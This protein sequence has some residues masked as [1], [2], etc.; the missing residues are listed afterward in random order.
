MAV[1]CVI[2]SKSCKCKDHLASRPEGLGT[3][4]AVVVSIIGYMKAL[5]VR[6]EMFQSQKITPKHSFSGVE[7]GLSALCNV[8]LA[9]ATT[10]SRPMSSFCIK[11]APRPKSQ[12]SVWMKNG[13]EKS[14]RHRMGSDVR[15]FFK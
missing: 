14:G 7:Y 2:E 10:T 6:S 15:Q 12:A 13:R 9:K 4:Q 3:P 11:A 8:L 1:G 5:N